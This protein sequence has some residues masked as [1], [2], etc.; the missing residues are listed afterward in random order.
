MPTLQ[1]VHGRIVDLRHYANAHLLFWHRPPGPSDRYE[2]WIKPREGVERNQATHNK[3]VSF[4][5]G[6]ADDVLRD[7]FRRGKYPDVI[8]SLRERFGVEEKNKAAV[9]RYPRS[10]RGRNDQA[11]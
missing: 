7:L 1:T 4:I 10:G 2:L 5:W 9:S 3:I 11:F 8:A 6:I